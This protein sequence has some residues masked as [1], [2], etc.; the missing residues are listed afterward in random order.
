MSNPL[1]TP[2]DDLWEVNRS[3]QLE[4]ALDGANDPRWVD[5][6]RAR[7]EYSLRPLYR[8]LG[9]EDVMNTSERRL[10]KPPDRGYHLFC[11]HLGCGKSTE[12]R[13]IRNDLHS[14]DLYYVVF[15]D[16]A[17]DLDPN[18]LRY[19]DIL[20]HLAARLART[21]TALAISSTTWRC[22]STTTTIGA[23]IPWSGL[24]LPTATQD[25]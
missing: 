11:G 16:A 4:D 3:L 10:E 12:L 21:P 20:L 22:W 23:V 19:Q 2:P 8:A 24:P 9:V 6:G 17:R 18:N 13:R 14:P 1:Y 5:T 15:A 7:G 25:A